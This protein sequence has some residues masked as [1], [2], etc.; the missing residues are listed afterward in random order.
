ME[1]DARVLR[2]AQFGAFVDLGGVDALLHNEDISWR[3][4]NH[5]GDEL[6]VGD[7]VQ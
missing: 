2:F 3:R 5:P 1:L 7:V 4:V 6:S